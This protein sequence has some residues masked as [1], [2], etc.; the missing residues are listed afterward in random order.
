MVNYIAAYVGVALYF[1]FQAFGL[2]VLVAQ[3]MVQVVPTA[4]ETKDKT[5]KWGIYVKGRH[6][7]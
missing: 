2:A 7:G 3:S 5:W 1:I 4:S 6:V